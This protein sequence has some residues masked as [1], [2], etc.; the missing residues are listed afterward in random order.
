MPTPSL[1]QAHVE[2]AVAD[3]P[4][5]AKQ[6]VNDA[7]EQLRSSG[8]GLAVARE[9]HQFFE[10]MEALQR[11]R[12]RLVQGWSQALAERIR[13]AARESSPTPVPR[14]QELSLDALSLVDE[15][16]AEEDIEGSRP[17]TRIEA[18][19]EWELSELQAYTA[20]RRGEAGHRG[21]DEDDDDEAQ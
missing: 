5:L 19:A 11:Q 21:S 3:A 15:H 8:L 13:E 20:A 4:T 7:V 9:R 1:F 16:Q 14:R 17:L 10:L 12:E 6:I 18:T 2:Q